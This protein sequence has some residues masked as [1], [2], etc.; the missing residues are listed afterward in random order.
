MQ[1]EHNSL[2]ATVNFLKWALGI[3]FSVLGTSILFSWTGLVRKTDKT[4]DKVQKLAENMSAFITELR[5]NDKRYNDRFAQIFEDI[6][7]TK[8]EI[9]EVGEKVTDIQIALAKK[10][11]K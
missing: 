10:G 1:V 4:E 8:N 2:E 6:K 5:E 11:K 9:K 3:A 7:E